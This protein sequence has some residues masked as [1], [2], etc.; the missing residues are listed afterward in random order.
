MLHTKT[1]NSTLFRILKQLMELG[2]FKELRLV[3]GTSLALQIG[4]RESI[5]IDLFGRIDFNFENYSEHFAEMG[6]VSKIKLSKHINILSIDNIK[7]DFV[8]YRY[9]WITECKDIDGLRL[10]SMEDIGAMKLNAITGRGAKKDFIDLYFLLQIFS[11]QDLFR[12]YTQKYD[13]GNVFLVKK[14]LVYFVDAER[15]EMPKMHSNVT[16]EEMKIFILDKVRKENF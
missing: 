1:V 3:G 2:S 4:H 5:D 16:W 7:V 11:F 13:D 12:F 8:N 10:A 15:E 14:S 6:A 9:P